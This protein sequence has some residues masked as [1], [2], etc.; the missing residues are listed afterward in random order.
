LTVQAGAAAGTIRCRAPASAAPPMTLP[1]PAPAPNK[2]RLNLLRLFTLL[3]VIALSFYIYS[4][5]DRADI[6]TRY[7]YPG[8]FLLAILANATVVLPAPGLVFVFGAG[9]LSAL[10]PLG[11]GLAAGLGATLGELSGYL[12]GFS[13][14]AVIEDRAM[15]ARLEDWMKRFGPATIVVLAFLP[16]PVFDLAG[17]AA[18]ALKMPAHHFLFWCALGKIPKMLLIAFLGQYAAAGSADWLLRIFR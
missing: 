18:G 9:M 3:F 11:V 6:L 12:A 5:R 7:G 14:Q 4:I 8:I 10:S 17:V 1:L 16:L 2:L 15:Y 13:G